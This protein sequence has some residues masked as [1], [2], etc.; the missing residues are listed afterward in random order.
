MHMHD[1]DEN[2][3]ELF[4]DCLGNGSALSGTDADFAWRIYFRPCP[5]KYRPGPARARARPTPLHPVG[6]IG[7]SCPR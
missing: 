5:A 3:V 6:R 2:E 1:P 4:V 7:G